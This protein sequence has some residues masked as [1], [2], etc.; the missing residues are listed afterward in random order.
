MLKRIIK[1]FSLLVMFFGE[2][3]SLPRLGSSYLH[4]VLIILM[5]AANRGRAEVVRLEIKSRTPVMGEKSYGSVGGYE[6][7]RGQIFFE[8]D[9]GNIRNQKI[10]DI[11]LAPVNE[12]GKVEANGN[13][14]ILKPIDH[15]KSSGITLVEVS[16]R[17]GK[18]SPRYFNR[19]GNGELNPV[20]AQ[21]FGDG[22]LME[23]GVTV[24][25]VGWQFDIPEEN[26]KL[27]LNL[28][29]A[30]NKDGSSI[31]GLVRSDWVIKETT[32]T[33]SIGHRQQIGYPVSVADDPV[34]VLTVRDERE[35]QRKI[36]PTT[37]WQFARLSEGEIISDSL[38]IYLGSGFQAGKIY[39]LVYRSQDPPVVGLGLGVVRDVISYAKYQENPIFSAKY[40]IAA[41]VSQTGRF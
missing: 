37:E 1:A 13:I 39:E 41:G 36:I 19:A 17:G 40:G 5:I 6:I 8:F 32:Q 30:R 26:D 25:W 21:S 14:I 3:F 31:T 11:Q 38:H 22:L 24:V 4:W 10:T 34:N 20:D 18:F 28:P 15:T 23:L 35:G 7:I 12:R 16:N 27:R 29:V 9:P 33:L 2:K